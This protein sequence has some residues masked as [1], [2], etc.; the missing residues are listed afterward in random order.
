MKHFLLNLLRPEIQAEIDKVTAKIVELQ[1][2][3]WKRMDAIEA[4]LTKLEVGVNHDIA[5]LQERLQ[6][7][8]PRNTH[9]AWSA[10]AAIAEAGAKRAG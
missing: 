5:E 8:R 7:P 3:D 9:R 4:H 1:R 2:A 10:I 6:Q